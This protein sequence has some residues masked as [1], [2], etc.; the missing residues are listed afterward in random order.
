MFLERTAAERIFNFQTWI[1]Q[2]FGSP[3]YHFR[4]QF[5][6]LSNGPLNGSN[7][8]AIYE[9]RQSETR[10]DAEI[11]FPADHTFLYKIGSWRNFTITSTETSHTKN[12]T[13][14]L[15]FPLVTHTT[16]FD[17]WFGCYGILKSCFS[18]GHVMNRLDCSCLVRFL[19]HKM[20]ETC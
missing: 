5:S 14:K 12:V 11:T 9:L 15:S 18:T 16:H 20:G 6:Q 13:N 1:S 3:E 7:W 2:N 4:R 17:I 8:L 10:S 19:G